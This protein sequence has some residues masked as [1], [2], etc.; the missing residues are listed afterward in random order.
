LPGGFHDVRFPLP[1]EVGAQGGPSYSTSIVT[2]LAGFEQRNANWSRPRYKWT[3]TVP[4]GD[5]D[6]FNELLDFFHARSGQ[7]YA[8]RFQ[9]PADYTAT[10]EALILDPLISKYRLA[11]TYSSGG[12]GLVRYITRPVSGSVTFS[13]GGT[14]DYTTGIITGGAA[15][16]WSGQFDVP[17]RF[18]TD[19]FTLTL[20][21][22]DVGTAAIDLIE[23][24]EA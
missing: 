9:D 21:Q 17:V 12:V 8:F 19:D 10:G 20:E 13:G 1:L 5:I 22:V 23:V 6:A 16:T 15:G 18:A 3:A 7:L 2:T 24:R 11:K 4:Y 14:L